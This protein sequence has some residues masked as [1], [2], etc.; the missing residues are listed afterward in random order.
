MSGFTSDLDERQKE[1]AE[2]RSKA[3]GLEPLRQPIQTAT[4]NVEII[5]A[6]NL[7][8]GTRHWPMTGGALAF[9]SEQEVIMQ[10]EAN[11][12]RADEE[13]GGRAK[14]RAVFSL[15]A[16]NPTVGKSIAILRGTHSVQIHFNKMEPN[17]RV[18]GGRAVVVINNAVKLDFTIAGDCT[19]C[20]RVR[21]ASL[22]GS[23]PLP[24]VSGRT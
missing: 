21:A 10:L 17:Q 7:G 16:T 12:S 3:E 1:I 9:L 13:G 15:D 2:L 22:R 18:F 24:R 8:A 6:S 14:Y 5:V 11:A 4:A 19:S 20:W 23:T